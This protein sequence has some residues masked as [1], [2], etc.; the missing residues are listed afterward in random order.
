VAAPFEF[1]VSGATG[2]R[3][4]TGDAI[5]NLRLTKG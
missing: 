3:K 1:S 4:I 2:S 5:G